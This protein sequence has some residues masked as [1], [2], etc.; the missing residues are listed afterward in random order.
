METPMVPTR[1][2]HCLASPRTVVAWG[3]DYA[4]I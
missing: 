4:S 1:R 2:V 3:N